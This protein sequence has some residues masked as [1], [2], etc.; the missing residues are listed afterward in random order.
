MAGFRSR[1]AAPPN[2]GGDTKE[3]GN[4]GTVRF[5]YSTSRRCR[6]R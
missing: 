6:L 4:K 3:N 2:D 5:V 1:K